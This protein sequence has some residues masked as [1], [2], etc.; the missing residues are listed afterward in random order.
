M[1]EVLAQNNDACMFVT[2]LCGIIN[3]KT[4]SIIM[5]NAGHM[6]PITKTADKTHE[7]EVKGA[8]ALGLMED[9]EYPDVEFN[10]NHNTSIVM[11]T[12]GISEAHNKSSQQYSDEKIISLIDNTNV[13]NS[14]FLGKSIIESVDDFAGDT[15]QFDD[16]TLL[17]IRYE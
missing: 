12:D 6:N 2:A 8:T 13:S 1:N 17:I 15:E 10:L 3:I 4:G 16:I 14:E 11:Y 9:I 5:S 7:Y